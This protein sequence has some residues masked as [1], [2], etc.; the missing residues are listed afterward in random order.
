MLA[1]DRSRSGPAL[2]RGSGLLLVVVLGL[3]TAVATMAQAIVIPLLP[4]M[5]HELGSS[6]AA[7]SWVL[8]GNLLAGT[9]AT[10]LF[11][12]L[13]DMRG[14]RLY[15]V[16]ALALST[17][18]MVVAAAGSSLALVVF[19]RVLQGPCAAVYPL[20]LA[21]A[22]DELPPERLRG[23]VGTLSALVSV[24]GGI[25]FL[26]A[27]VVAELSSGYRAVFW[28]SAVAFGVSLIAVLAVVRESPLR[29]PHRLD[30]PG[31]AGLVGWLVCLLLAISEGGA[32]GWASGATIALF[33]AAAALFALWCLVERRVAAPL[34]DFEVLLRPAV[35]VANLGILAI[36]FLMYALFVSVDEF[37][38]TPPTAGYGFGASVL[39]AA[40]FLLPYSG[41]S[42][43]GRPAG[44]W[45]ARRGIRLET[46]LLAGLLAAAAGYLLA[47]LAHRH[48]WELYV[49]TAGIGLGLGL[50]F[51]STPILL[52]E[53]VPATQTGVAAGINTIMRTIGQALGSAAAG[54]LL[55]AAPGRAPSSSRYVA[56][57]LACA[58]VAV[59]V[60]PAVAALKSPQAQPISGG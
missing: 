3:A 9:V 21:I 55:A 41:A 50:G 1:A 60:L 54:A 43:A 2:S 34:V 31:A 51:V 36:G 6:V 53:G 39:G 22:R 33:V 28:V 59:L 15:L 56:G 29:V 11:G 18:G 4:R 5:Q 35:L 45:L 58:A 19:G 13:G 30:L 23:G 20:C 32:W 10:P 17:V 44:T 57:W 12:R 42:V 25:G 8:T 46:V 7:V 27:G 38:Q 40:L 37:V 52:V 49:A 16:L 48:G 14:K 26:I 24:G 47:A